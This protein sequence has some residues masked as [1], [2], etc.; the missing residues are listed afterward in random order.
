MYFNLATVSEAVCD[1]VSDREAIIFKDRRIT[2]GALQDRSRR[3]ANLLLDR[4]LGLHTPRDQLRDWES[5]QDH[6]GIYLYNGNEYLEGMLGAFKARLA[7]FNINYRYVDEELVYLLNNAQTRVL[8]YHSSL[9]DSVRT[10]R[11]RVPSIELLVQVADDGG[12]LL[13][14]A[15][16]YERALSESDARRPD[17]E[18]D[19]DDLYILYTGGTTGMPKG[20]LWRHRDILIATLGGRR[21]NG[22]ILESLNEYVDRAR[23]MSRKSLPAPPFM[24]GAGHWN[25]LQM[26]NAG[27]TVVIQDDV[28]RF[29]PKSVLEIIAREEVTTLLIVGDAFGR[30]LADELA[31]NSH[32]VSS[33]R[34][35]ITGGA[36]MTASVK[37]E[38]IELIPQVNI[39]DS[40]GSSETG[41]QASHVSNAKAGAETGRFTL[42]PNNAVLAEDRS[43]VLPPGHEGLGWWARSGNIPLGYLDDEAKTRE[44]FPTVEG[45][46]YSIPGDKVRLLSDSTLELHGR[47]SITINSGGEKIFAE[48][49]EQ[50]VKHH[51]A[52]FDAVVTG[53]KSERWGNEVV[54][55]VHLKDGAAATEESLIAECERHIARYKLPKAFIFLDAIVRSPSGK[56]DYRWAKDIVER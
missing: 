3:L 16:D 41:G 35:I 53:R 37:R 21:V 17:V 2:Y 39:I 11:D 5:G 56:A 49:V 32:N 50:A 24:H 47:E 9:A 23:G 19:P 38:L 15:L 10:I 42:T 30:P 52:V 14:G 13:P 6:L 1:V 40:A 48:E 34:N 36:I 26:L 12:D 43:R 55:I 54:A 4:G 44:T 28:L 51:S 31:N 27:G 20:V 7:P 18:W 29:D 46:K 25:A 45:V 22:H 33:L 8:L